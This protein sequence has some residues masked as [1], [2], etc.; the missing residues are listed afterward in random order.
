MGSGTLTENIENHTTYKYIPH[1]M[2]IP[3]L[4]S[5]YFVYRFIFVFFF[6]VFV[7]CSFSLSP[8][9][10]ENKYMLI[11]LWLYSNTTAQMG[12]QNVW[13]PLYVCSFIYVCDESFV[14]NTEW[15]DTC[16]TRSTFHNWPNMRVTYVMCV[17][18]R[19]C[20]PASLCMRICR[21]L[22]ILVC[23]YFCCAC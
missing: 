15:H 13:V 10:Y 9:L 5:I 23:V 14:L 16:A 2:Y 4:C 12:S 11:S 6:F 7:L 17:C 20:A 22:Y 19:A 21:C 8:H 1:K 3:I 18:L